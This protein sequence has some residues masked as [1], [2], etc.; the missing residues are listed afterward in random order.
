MATVNFLYRST[1]PDAPLNLRLL[2]THNETDF[3][4]GGK[5]QKIVSKDYWKNDHLK[6][7]INDIDR[8]NFQAE[9]K[10][11]LTDLQRYILNAFNKVD[12]PATIDKKWLKDAVNEFYSPTKEKPKAPTNL[13]DFFLFYADSKRNN[14][15]E[16]RL[17]R[18]TVVRNKILRYEEHTGKTVLISNVN[19]VFKNSFIDYGKNHNYAQNTLK[20]DLS[21][22]RTVCTYA[23][24]WNIKT[25]PQLKDLRIGAE[26]ITSPYL[27][28]DE[29]DKIKNKDFPKGG[30]LDNARDWLIISCYTGQRVSDFLKFTTDKVFERK[31]KYFLEFTQTKTKKRIVIPFLKEAKAVFDK[32]GGNFP[33][34]LSSQK[35]NDYIKEVCKESGIDEPTTGKILVCL[36]DDPKTATR[37]DYRREEKTVPKYELVSTHIGRRSLAT[38]FYGKVPTNYLILMTGHSTEREF[39]NYIQKPE[40]DKAADAFKY[41]E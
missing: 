5:T 17:R 13:T 25:S 15:S 9:V 2:F 31:G 19:D 1:R 18:L 8:S 12:N 3:V 27:N 23:E 34:P 16:S 39:L 36:A 24:Q 10:Q 28:F 38:N 7:R 14:L 32:H 37:N 29:L 26:E 30:Y 4:I 21:I 40:K 35:Y 41:F 22:I 6:Q 20:A 11:H 33:R